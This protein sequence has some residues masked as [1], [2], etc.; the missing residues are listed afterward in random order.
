MWLQLQAIPKFV[1][2]VACSFLQL[3]S[4]V[5]GLRLVRCLAFNHAED[6]PSV[7]SVQIGWAIRL[8]GM[9]FV[10]SEPACWVEKGWEYEVERKA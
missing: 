4:D 3:C 7:A 9:V 8:S 10:A 1:M 2:V 5:F 6:E